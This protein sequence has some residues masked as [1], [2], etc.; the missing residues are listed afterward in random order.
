MAVFVAVACGPG[1]ALAGA[2]PATDAYDGIAKDRAVDVHA[3][4]DLYTQLR[5]PPGGKVQLRAFDVRSDALAL[6]MLRLTVAHHPDLIGFRLDVGVG[7]MPNAYLAADPASTTHPDLSRWLSYFEQGFVT[8]TLPVGGGVSVDVGKF[9]TPV[10]LEDNET[11]QNWNYSRG[12]LFALGEPTYHTGLRVTYPVTDS[13]GISAFWLN[14]WNTNVA[15]GNGMRSFAVAGSW[16]PSE[17]MDL[18]VTYA[19]GPERA[20]TYLSDPRLAFRNIVD[21]YGSFAPR[22]WLILAATADYATDASSGGVSWWGVG[23][24]ARCLLLPWLAGVARAEHFSDPDG[25]TTSVRQRVDEITATAEATTHVAGLKL[26]GRLEY[27]HDQSDQPVFVSA[28][29]NRVTRQDT[30]TLGVM[31]AF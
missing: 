8:A 5:E 17:T 31:T 29:A 10:G 6:E 19:A 15:E 23:G 24:Y 9:D 28:G 12:L 16:R 25:F 27:R 3:M 1:T 30:G 20:P 2:G 11:M 22:P 26:V 18:V 4:A 13:L 7:D 14:G 21:V